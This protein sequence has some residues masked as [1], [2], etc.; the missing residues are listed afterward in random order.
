MKE[1]MRIQDGICVEYLPGVAY[2]EE[3][4][5][6]VDGDQSRIGLEQPIDERYNAWF[7][8]QLIEITGI[9][10]KPQIGWSYD[11]SL[12]A[13]PAT[14]QPTDFL[15]AQA[16]IER[17]RQLKSVYDPGIMMALRALRMASTPE[18]VSYAEGKVY[19]LDIY[20]EAL[21]A[22]PSQTGFPQTITWPVAPTK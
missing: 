20:A 16:R 7:I 5:G 9:T 12:F 2:T 6:W 21:V 3:S 8:A 13:P 1:Y 14:S 22:V 11:G 15:A 17:D 10:P 19:E 4:P 18:Q